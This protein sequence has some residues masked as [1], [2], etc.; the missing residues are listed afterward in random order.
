MGNTLLRLLITSI[1][2]LLVAKLMPG[3]EVSSGWALIFTAILLGVFNAILRPIMIIL[4][5]PATL[6]TF[7]LFIFIINGAI[8]Y[9][10]AYFVDGFEISGLFA[11]VIA[12]ILISIVS[13]IV[14]WLA[15]GQSR[16][17]QY[18]Y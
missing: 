6:L 8:L 7:G 5:L 18:K 12:S 17:K 9:L 16:D 1:A 10:I 3:I 2:V 14:N 15:K 13:G 11:A 4:T